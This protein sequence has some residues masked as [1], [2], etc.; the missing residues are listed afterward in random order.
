MTV[1]QSSSTMMW[2]AAWSVSV[3]RVV[4]QLFS[5]PEKKN[6]D[7]DL[8]RIAEDRPVAG[9]QLFRFFQVWMFD[10]VRFWSIVGDPGR[11]CASVD[12]RGGSGADLC[13][14][15]VLGH[16][17]CFRVW[18]VDWARLIVSRR[19]FCRGWLWVSKVT[20]GRSQYGEMELGRLSD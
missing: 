15:L 5:W 12:E 10:F 6:G 17:G 7:D 9:F 13:G 2:S 16:R 20:G 8:Q 3:R 18:V 11:S 14:R 4:G 1:P 19:M